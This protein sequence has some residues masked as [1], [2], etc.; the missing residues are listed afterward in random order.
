MAFPA[1]PD[2]ADRV[3]HVNVASPRHVPTLFLIP[4]RVKKKPGYFFPVAMGSWTTICR[5]F[6]AVLNMILDVAFFWK[7]VRCPLQSRPAVD[8]DECYKLVQLVLGR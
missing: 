5:I 7:E 8:V 3:K 1:C 6:F 2:P 4:R